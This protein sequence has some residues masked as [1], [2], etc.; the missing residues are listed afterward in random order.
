MEKTSR[1]RQNYTNW[2]LKKVQERE[3]RERERPRDQRDIPDREIYQIERKRE[4]ED[5]VQNSLWIR[6]MIRNV[7]ILIS[8][9]GADLTALLNLGYNLAERDIF[10]KTPRDV[11]VESGVQD[12]INAIGKYGSLLLPISEQI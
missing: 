4:R 10:C 5:R 9:T 8:A 1:D 7:Q 11:A 6:K 12:N 3:I 2:Q